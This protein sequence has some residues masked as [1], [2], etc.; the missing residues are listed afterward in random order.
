MQFDFHHPHNND[1]GF[2]NELLI[3]LQTKQAEFE[4]HLIPDLSHLSHFANYA[5]DMRFEQV[6]AIGDGEY[7]LHYSFN[8]QINN[9]CA[10]QLHEGRIN[11]KVRFSLPAQNKIEFH[12]ITF[13]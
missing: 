9:A 12:L 13:G 10:D 8:W 4:S 2:I 3:N 5:G 6:E 7:R 1:Q 11:E